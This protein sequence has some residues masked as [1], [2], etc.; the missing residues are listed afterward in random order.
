M[1]RED[2]GAAGMWVWKPLES[3]RLRQCSPRTTAKAPDGG[4]WGWGE[5]RSDGREGWGAE[6]VFLYSR[7]P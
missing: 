5:Q 4:L 7:L 1:T 2:G 3:S 6:G